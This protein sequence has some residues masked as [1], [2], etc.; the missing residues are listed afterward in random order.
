MRHWQPVRAIYKIASSTAR[1]LVSRGRPNALRAG[2]E[3]SITAHSASV[4]SL[5]YRCPARSYFGRV[6]SVHML[7]LGDC[8]T[9]PLCYNHLKS[10][11]SF[12]VSLFATKI[13]LTAQV[14]TNGTS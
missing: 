8:S 1:Q 2:M 4:R 9:Q 11:N 12:P 14:T 10:L 6:I 3:G 7:Y 5:A 13:S